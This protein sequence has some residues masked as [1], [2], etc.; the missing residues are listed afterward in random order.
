VLERS[1]C[2]IG[3]RLFTGERETAPVPPPVLFTDTGATGR[4][5]VTPSSPTRRR[6]AGR[7]VDPRCLTVSTVVVLAGEL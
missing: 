5:Q 4:L 1:A 6:A 2:A 7:A 3:V